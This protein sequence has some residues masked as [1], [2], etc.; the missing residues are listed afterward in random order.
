MHYSFKPEKVCSNRI[1]LD[2]TDNRVHN[3]TYTGG[4][5]GNLKALSALAEGLTV[6]ELIEKLSG[7]RCGRSS[8]S[9]GDQLARKLMSIKASIES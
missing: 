3:I 7:I 4:C 6:D 9:C 5:N 1:E 8:T 2:V